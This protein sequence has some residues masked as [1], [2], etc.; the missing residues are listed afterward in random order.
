MTNFTKPLA[1]PMNH[2]VYAEM[3]LSSSYHW[4]TASHI[5]NLDHTSAL[6]ETSA[7][8]LLPW[9]HLPLPLGLLWLL[10]ILFLLIIDLILSSHPVLSLE[11]KIGMCHVSLFFRTIDEE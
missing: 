10:N 6:C 4:T 7:R 8:S 1:Q 2:S 9:A 3:T 11:G 5:L